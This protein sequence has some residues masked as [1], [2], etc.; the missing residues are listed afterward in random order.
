M[1][2]VHLEEF[3]R[4]RKFSVGNSHGHQIPTVGKFF[5]G[6]V[7]LNVLVILA[8]RVA[9]LFKLMNVGVADNNYN[10]DHIWFFCLTLETAAFMLYFATDSV[11]TENHYELLAFV[12]CAFILGL[13]SILEYLSRD[14][15]AGDMCTD[16]T[17]LGPFCI[18]STFAQCGFTIFYIA[19]A[20]AV[21]KSYGWRFYKGMFYFKQSCLKNSI[22]LLFSQ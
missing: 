10:T 16:D 3:T 6:S 18:A 1:A 7:F 13:R 22:S 11:H 2:P 4:I 9:V 20:P 5:L 14:P 17:G 12:V 8:Y 19:I 15:E 21:W